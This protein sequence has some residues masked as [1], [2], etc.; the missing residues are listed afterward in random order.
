MNNHLFTDVR[1]RTSVRLLTV[2]ASVLLSLFSIWLH[3]H[4]NNDAFTYIRT[5]EIALH[6][7]ISG[8]YEHYEWAHFSVLMAAVHSISGLSLLNAAY[9]INILLFALLCASFVSV[10]ATMTQSNRV[11][12]LAAVVILLYPHLNEFRPY[13]IRDT[14]FLAFMLLSLLH[15]LYYSRSLRLRYGIIFIAATLAASLFRPEALVYLFLSPVAVLFNSIH[16]ISD[17]RKAWYRLQTLTLLLAVLAS[18][19]F[20]LGVMDL[21]SQLQSFSTIYAPFLPNLE[22]LMGINNTALSHALF[23]EY[24]SQFVGN[25]VGWF[26][27]AGLIALLVAC[28]IDSLGLVV[29]PLLLF[30]LW[31]RHINIP[32]HAAGVLVTYFLVSALIL[33]AFVLLTRFVTT[34][35][36]LLLCTLLL[37]LLP[38]LID[39]LWSLA[40]ASMRLRRFGVLMAVVALYSALDAHVSF[41]ASKAHITQGAAWIAQYTRQNAPLLTNEF[42]IAY[43]SGRIID[44]DLIERNIS[45]E[46]IQAARPGT[47][48]AITPRRDIME[49]VE[50]AMQRGELRLLQRFDAERG[51]DLLVLEKEL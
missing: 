36:T 42:Y 32:A 41:G 27:I 8:A 2:A 6:D 12:W 34:R 3:E 1:N 26:L 23:G 21:G 22:Q 49:Y 38:L 14:G 9:L 13:I 17:R 7:G 5:A 50:Q 37:M 4:P 24:A 30:G 33:L 45:A 31:R 46:T 28:V 16:P 19:L 35:Y 18:T 48:V 47:I 11:V 20:A 40:A 15:L 39:R 51:A 10:V 29:A 44:Y 25:Y 43:E